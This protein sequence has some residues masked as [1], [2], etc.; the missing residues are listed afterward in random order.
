[1]L[2]DPREGGEG[3]FRFLDTIRAYAQTRLRDSGEATDLRARHAAFFLGVAENAAAGQQGPEQ[4]HGFDLLEREHD[5]CRAALTD[6]Q[7]GAEAR[8]R[9]AGALH[10]FWMV[11][12]H[13]SEGRGHI[14]AALAAAVAVDPPVPD[15]IRA[16]AWNGAGILAMA[17][18]DLVGARAALGESLRLYRPLGD[19]EA[20]A[21]T[22]NNLAIVES[23]QES[24]AA[25]RRLYEEAHDIYQSLGHEARAAQVLGNLGAIAMQQGDYEAARAYL[26]ECLP[27]HERRGDKFSLA[28]ALENLGMTALHQG[29]PEEALRLLRNSLRIRQEIGDKSLLA[30]TLSNIAA[31]RQERG[32]P[33]G[34]VRL[35]AAAGAVAAVLEIV[36]SESECSD[37][38]KRLEALRGLLG[39][40]AFSA[41]WDAGRAWTLEQAVADA[42]GIAA[43]ATDRGGA[44]CISMERRRET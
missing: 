22:L 38:E 9:L 10:W 29:D 2:A 25:A 23:K 16:K 27:R 31:A 15:P 14:E 43:G 7:T 12:G 44:A 13:L 3:R 32:D 20:I 5:N 39:A 24:F 36:P 1:V 34:S 41:A 33:V 11:R 17:A 28:N 42:L 35:F 6:E 19:A 40:D 4:E 37:L 30:L 18:G 21:K 8:L 26:R